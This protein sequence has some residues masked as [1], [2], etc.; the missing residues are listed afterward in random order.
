MKNQDETICEVFDSI[1]DKCDSTFTLLEE[2][3]INLLIKM[4]RLQTMI[5]EKVDLGVIRV[6]LVED[7]EEKH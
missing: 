1:K 4:F 7:Y 3:N 6:K 2:M 5:H